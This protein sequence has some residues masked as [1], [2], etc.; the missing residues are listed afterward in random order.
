MI[1]KALADFT[2]R[3][4]SCSQSE[5]KRLSA[6]RVGID[7]GVASSYGLTLLVDSAIR[8]LGALENRSNQP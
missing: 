8:L 6:R 2:R 5:S 7:R 4:L 3:I 1:F